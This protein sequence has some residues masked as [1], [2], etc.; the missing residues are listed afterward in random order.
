M[1]TKICTKCGEEKPLG[2]FHPDKRLK[3]PFRS[4][5]KACVNA[6]RKQHTKK[7]SE[8]LNATARQYRKQHL[9]AC[10]KRSRDWKAKNED[11]VA[12]YQHEY[13]KKITSYL[14]DCVIKVKLI[15]GKGFS[16]EQITPEL[17]G[18]Q[19]AMIKLKRAVKEIQR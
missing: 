3:I 8:R 19:R 13:N 6:R 11:R 14:P 10:R 1:E 7:N 4:Q 5:C 12:S 15:H 18:A 16:K 9:D 2:G 17:I